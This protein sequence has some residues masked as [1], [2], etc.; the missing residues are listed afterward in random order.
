MT[1]A[2]LEDP[3]GTALTVDLPPEVVANIPTVPLESILEDMK[4]KYHFA[5]I[6]SHTKKDIVLKFQSQGEMET[7]VRRFFGA[8]TFELDN[9]EE[10]E[11]IVGGL[12]G[13][14]PKVELKEYDPLHQNKYEPVTFKLYNAGDLPLELT[15]VS[16]FES[17]NENTRYDAIKNSEEDWL[18]FKQADL[19]CT[20]QPKEIKEIKAEIVI[21][22]YQSKQ[23]E[24]FGFRQVVFH[25]A[26]EERFGTVASVQVEFGST[27]IAENVYVGIDFGTSI[28][29]SVLPMD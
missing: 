26:N 12:L 9:G 5:P 20:L 4:T 27:V 6:S 16:V 8:L 25:H 15:G 29:W 17:D 2:D 19:Y 21:G 13:H 14:E 23:K 28:P 22:N 3:T 24:T 10:L 11:M 18:L 1:F 7:G